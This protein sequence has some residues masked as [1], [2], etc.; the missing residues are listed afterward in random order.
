VTAVMS[1]IRLANIRCGPVSI[2]HSPSYIVVNP[3]A[4]HVPQPAVRTRR[5]I[6]FN[7]PFPYKFKYLIQYLIHH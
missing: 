3:T 1:R 7:G 4:P 6:W 2:L 5:P